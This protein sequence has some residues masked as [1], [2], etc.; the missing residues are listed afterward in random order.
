MT[1]LE[2]PGSR[3]VWLVCNAASGSNSEETVREV[4]TAFAEVGLDLQRVIP[5]P[6]EPAPDKGELAEAGVDILAVFGGD[7]TV[8]AVMK[9]AAQW[10]GPVLVL[11]GGTMNLLSKRVHGDVPAPEIVTRL[12]SGR[13]RCTRPLVIRTRYGI[14][15]TGVLAG[16]GAIW[17]EVREALRS[18]DLLEVVATTQ[19]AIRHSTNA[20]K[21]LCEEVDCGRDEGYAA[22][23]VTPQDDGL[24]ANGY[25][26]ETLGDYA[27][28]GIALLNRNFRDGPHDELGLHDE[29]RLVC[30]EGEPMGLLIDGEPFD[31][32]AEETFEPVPCEMNLITTIDEVR[33]DAR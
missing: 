31:G 6:D 11:P 8:H 16:P 26:A 3:I 12:A 27:G 2:E 14:A 5:F 33:G 24:E 13:W 22:I 30:P 15:L 1:R 20:P 17:N 21:V 23:T 19:E 4:R 25:Y 10:D 32:S 7:G 18:V 28:Q 9:Q 29:V